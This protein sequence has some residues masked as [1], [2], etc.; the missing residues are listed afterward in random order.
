MKSNPKRLQ[1]R[2]IILFLLL[3]GCFCFSQEAK[4][5]TDLIDSLIAQKNLTLANTEFENQIQQ[6]IDKEN[7]DSIYK[8]VSLKG[9][10]IQLESGSK[11]AITEVYRFINELEV[12]KVPGGIFLEAHRNADDFFYEID[13]RQESLNIMLK[14]YQFLNEFEDASYDEI[15]KV[16]YSLGTAYHGLY[17][18]LKAQPYFK[19]AIVAYRKSEN[20]PKETL[21]DAY[22]GLAITYWDLGKLDSAK[23]SFENAMDA[24][25]K[26][27]LES[28]EK[29]FY[30][31]AFQFNIALLHDSQ[32][33]LNNAIQVSEK[34]ANGCHYIIKNCP[35][36]ELVEKA[37]GLEAITVSNLAA[38]YNDVGF[39]SRALQLNKIAYQK[40]KSFFGIKNPRTISAQYQLSQ[41]FLGLKEYEEAI[42]YAKKAITSLNSSSSEY[43]NLKAQVYNHLGNIYVEM[44]SLN[45]AGEYYER[46]NTLF[47]SIFGNDINRNYQQ[48]LRDYT[49]YLSKSEKHISAMNFANQAYAY[50]Q[51]NGPDEFPL[52]KNLLNLSQINYS[53]EKYS[54]A[55]EWAEKGDL[56]LELKLKSAKSKIDS[57]QI[58]FYRPNLILLKLKSIYASIENPTEQKLV[59][60]TSNLNKAIGILENRKY[61][62]TSVSDISALISE[63]QKISSFGKIIYKDLFLLSKKT[64]YLDSLL[65]LHESS[66]YHKIRERLNTK[67]DLI[68]AGVPEKIINRERKLKS[69]LNRSLE[70]EET[71]LKKFFQVENEFE[72]FLDTLK[73]FHTDY[74]K[75]K[76]ASISESLEKSIKSIPQNT[77]IVRY[78]LI[79][80]DWFAYIN[81]GEN[82][83]FVQ[84]PMDNKQ[85]FVNPELD[86]DS[87]ETF[88]LLYQYYMMLWEPL[89]KHLNSKNIIIIPDK[90]L[91]NLSFEIL[92]SEKIQDFKDL[93][94]ISLLSKYN[95]SYNYSLF[96]L[97]SSKK[98]LDFDENFI[99]FAPEFN[100]KMKLNYQGAIKDS[101]YL[102]KAYLNFLP[103]PFSLDIA[104]K[105]G[106]QFS[107]DYY[108]NENASKNVFTKNAGEHKIIHIG[109]HAESN[110]V[111]PE[112]SRLVFA[113]NTSD[114]TSINDNYLYTYEIYNQNLNS[115]LAILTACETGKPS[116]QPGEGMISLAHAFNYAGSESI[117]TSLWQIDEQSSTQILE[118]FYEYLEEGKP[119][120]E[121]LRSA[122]LDYLKTAEGRTL[123]PQYWAGLV[124]M[125][126]TTPIDLNSGVP[127]WVWLIL[128]LLAV[129]LITFLIKGKKESVK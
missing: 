29:L 16:N 47:E 109:T 10:I 35:D 5:G 65:T 66:I 113:K 82:E 26:S 39:L 95:I 49:D 13:E 68:F 76:Y 20:T 102:D 44:D 3:F 21:S 22:N 116:Y 110:N 117:L 120:D 19:K 89:E 92:T 36:L 98:L 103:Q 28:F 121:A 8:Y 70:S 61:F 73:I 127:W 48:H 122:K 56:F 71:D 125:G 32:G 101:T 62:T 52:F 69:M 30:E 11:K 1:A 75:I 58:E 83:N 51:K 77:V 118:F 115:N 27:Q 78:I 53:A 90:Q 104:K 79:G 91:F 114:S 33:E 85:S 41:S 45:A 112:L 64:E 88:S 9:K 74:Y 99:A 4:T 38:F 81:N 40:K 126:D 17:D 34:V 15:G 54:D 23:V 84:L 55:L 43:S 93:S 72:K 59:N 7:Y 119:K 25:A 42:N 123:H 87:R 124:L 108:L 50:N 86:M 80:S 97:D 24:V 12:L 46:S 2:V 129:C 105:F 57:L 111:S 106:R 18:M 107:G 60:L 100:S 67:S 128:P 31:I 6:I 37:K 96:L 94:E 14:A 63:Y